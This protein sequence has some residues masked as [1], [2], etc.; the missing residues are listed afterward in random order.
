MHGRRYEKLNERIIT[1]LLDHDWI[2][3]AQEQRTFRGV[4]S[5]LPFC[6]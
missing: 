6:F 4:C 3:L 2:S 1:A 5:C